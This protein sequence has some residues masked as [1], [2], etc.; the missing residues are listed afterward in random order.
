MKQ[1]PY[2]IIEFDNTTHRSQVTD[3]WRSVF[4]PGAPHNAPEVA[5]D[6]KIR[7]A[8]GLFFVAEM[9]RR[10]IGTIMAGY[11]GHRGWLYSVAVHPDHRNRGIG[12]D[13]LSFTLEKLNNLGCMKINLQILEENEAVKRFYEANGFTVEKRISMGKKLY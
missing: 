3:L 10:V 1:K 13:L 12:S 6:M 5:I 4:G 9:D 7:H 2:R 8:D 11:D